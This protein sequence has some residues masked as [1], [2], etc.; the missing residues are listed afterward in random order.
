MQ[1]V[2]E[3]MWQVAATGVC[4]PFKQGIASFQAS[5]QLAA[6]TL[7]LQPYISVWGRGAPPGI[8][9]LRLAPKSNL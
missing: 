5:L 1:S 6:H 7:A 9:G 2:C 3:A 4:M 8:A